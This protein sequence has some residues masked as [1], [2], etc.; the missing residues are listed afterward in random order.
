MKHEASKSADFHWTTR[1]YWEDTDGGGVVYHANYVRF[2]ERARTEW[3]R[4]KGYEQQALLLA[5]GVVFAVYSM[6][7]QFLKPARLDDLLSI[8]VDLRACRRAS[9]AVGQRIVDARGGA[10]LCRA[11]VEIA[12]LDHASFRPVP[13]P[14]DLL[15]EIQR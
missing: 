2:L 10:E 11:E 15:M 4:A 13:M 9:F 3:L 6:Q 1:V 12:C 8:S 14:P 7:L 5:K